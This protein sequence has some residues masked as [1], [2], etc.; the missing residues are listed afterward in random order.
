MITGVRGR[1]AGVL[2][3]GKLGAD[4]RLIARLHLTVLGRP[5]TL[6]VIPRCYR[7][8]IRILRFFQISKNMS[9]YVF[10]K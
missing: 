7:S 8:R 2:T 9:F 4:D 3:C 1:D 6:S 10:L 5:I